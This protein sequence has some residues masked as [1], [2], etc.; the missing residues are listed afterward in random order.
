MIKIMKQSTWEQQ[1]NSAR[2][3]GETYG[4]ALGREE[5][6]RVAV[7]DLRAIFAHKDK[8]HLEPV[9]LVGDE[10]T[11][12]NLGFAFCSPGILIKAGSSSPPTD[13]REARFTGC[14]PGIRVE[15]STEGDE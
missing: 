10:N 6:Y 2:D 14:E 5:G 15:P 1:L 8:I 3:R 9:T 4:H 11:L 12:N 13:I 7:E